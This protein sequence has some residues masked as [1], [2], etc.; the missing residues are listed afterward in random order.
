[1]QWPIQA[2]DRGRLTIK[3]LSCYTII[4][5]RLETLYTK[6]RNNFII[7]GWLFPERQLSKHLSIRSTLAIFDQDLSQTGITKQISF[8]SLRDSF[9]R[10]GDMKGNG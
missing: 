3:T 1:M 4:P 5:L 2:N 9:G 10:K 6:Y 8:Y 7:H